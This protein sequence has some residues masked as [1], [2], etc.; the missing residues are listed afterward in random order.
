MQS[1]EKY[2]DSGKDLRQEKG[3]TEDEVVGWHHWLD[4]H[5][6]EQALRVGEGQGS[7]ACCSPWVCKESDTTEWLIW[8]ELLAYLRLLIIL[9]TILIPACESSSLTF[10]RMHT[11]Y[12]L[13]KQGDNYSLAVLLSNLELVHCSMSSSN[14]FLIGVQISQQTVKVV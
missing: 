11:A 1:I 7:L 5:E 8:T 3:M 12:E 9:M 4:G 6:F 2:P 10:C 14:C 13:N